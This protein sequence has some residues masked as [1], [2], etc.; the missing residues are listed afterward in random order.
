MPVNHV[1]SLVRHL[2]RVL[3]D[4]AEAADGALLERF[5]RHAD[6]AAFAA[7]VRRHGPLVWR[8]SR[9]VARHEQDAEDVYQAT[10]LLL[11]R[12]AGAIRK[13]GSVGSWLYGVAHRLA[14][15]VRCDAAR[16]RQREARAAGPAAAVATD[17][18]TWH[19][20]RQVFHEELDRLPEKYRAPLLLCY[21]GGLTQDE[22]ARQLGWSRRAVKDRL[23]R[24]RARLRA[25]LARRGLAPSVILAGSLLAGEAAPA[26]APAALTAATLRAA[27]PFALRRPPGGGVS[28][29]ALAL[30]EGGLTTLGAGKLHVLAVGLLAAVL[31]GGAGLLAGRP[32]A[33]PA[34]EPA[35]VKQPQRKA[36]LDRYGDPL[37]PAALMRLGT[38]RY[39]FPERAVAF[40]ADGK[41]VVSAQA[42]HTLPLWN[43]RT[44]RLVREIDTGRLAVGLYVAFSRGARRVAVSGPLADAAGVRAAIVVFD[45]ASGKAL[46]TFDRAPLEGVNALALTPGGKLLLSL[47]RDGMLRVEE[48]ETG[49]ELRRQKFPGDVMAAIDLSPDGRALALASGPNTRRLFVWNWQTDEQPRE[50]G[51]KGR[52]A[53]AVVFAPDGKRL[54]HCSDADATVNIRDVASGR[55]LHRL[56]LPDHAPYRHFH[57]AF[58][59]D[60]KVLAASG[61]FREGLRGDVHLW[62]AVTGKFLRRLDLGYGGLAF[63]P[64]GGRGGVT[65][66]LLAAGSRVWDLAAG[67]ELSAND[68]AHRGA[69]ERVVTAGKD[70]VATAASDNTVRVWDAATG[71]QRRRLAPG[72]WLR[73]I[74]LSPDGRWLVSSSLLE[75]AVCLW[76]VTTGQQIYR[77]RGHGRAGVQ[78]AVAFTPDGKVL[79]SW[80]TDMHLRQWDVRTGK[81][82]RDH[83]LRPSG[84]KLPGEDARARELEERMLNLG[85]G[86]FTPDGK[87]LVLLAGGHYFVFDC[88]TG[89]ELRKFP[90]EVPGFWTAGLAVSPDGRLLVASARQAALGHAVTCWDLRTGRRRHQ[91]ALPEEEAGPV[92]FSPDGRRFAVAPARPGAPIRIVEVLSGREAYRIKGFRGVVR[93]L[94]FLPD[95]RRLVSGMDDSSALVWDLTRRR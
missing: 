12:K 1:T 30:A 5:A 41:T 55:L 3:G 71:K 28:A 56:E 92:A 50:I 46:R 2:R 95:G 6:E 76:D 16:R 77:L 39:R 94:A 54:A 42:G 72:G 73:A 86:R 53:C 45:T 63:S 25:R 82:V 36:R 78:R 26:A 43:A 74:A 21:F 10:F 32:A 75:D 80:G 67:R 23:G 64:D 33:E 15:R 60:G 31:L 49:R 27:V 81:A 69:V 14:L 22:A 52:R 48:V 89:K 70:V 7:L 83:A 90:G 91:L 29:Q 24:G 57:L 62:D 84:V 88:D 65:P 8:V 37:P 35:V 44:G 66:P 58:A 13:A 20:L 51:D 17:D 85:G 18:H 40:L 61:L 59:P 11:A 19:E 68:E 38:V 4:R 79:L 9:R 34:P 87:H 47:G 93:S